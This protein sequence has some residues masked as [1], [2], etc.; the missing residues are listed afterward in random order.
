MFIDE[1][2]KLDEELLIGVLVIQ[3]IKE[4]LLQLK[5]EGESTF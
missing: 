4:C 2:G 1:K 5:M 3:A